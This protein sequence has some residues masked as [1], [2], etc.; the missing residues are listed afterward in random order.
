LASSIFL[1]DGAARPAMIAAIAIVTSSS[2][3]E[4]PRA[5]PGRR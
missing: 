4:K 1:N 5:A 2:M 3:S